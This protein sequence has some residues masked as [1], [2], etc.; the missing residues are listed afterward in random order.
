MFVSQDPPCTVRIL[1]SEQF[2]WSTRSRLETR[3]YNVDR[4]SFVRERTRTAIMETIATHS[5]SIYYSIYL[6]LIR[7]KYTTSGI[8]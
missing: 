2:L 7:T 6:I 3:A 4:A 8:F 1:Q 5:S